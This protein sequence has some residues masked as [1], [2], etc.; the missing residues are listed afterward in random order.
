MSSCRI[1]KKPC[2]NCPFLKSSAA[3]PR[4]KGRLE[5]IVEGLLQDDLSTFICHKTLQREDEDEGPVYDGERMCAGAAIRLL[6]ERRPNV[7]MR[8]EGSIDRTLFPTW[9]AQFELIKE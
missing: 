8:V 3:I 1:L 2:S 7:I 6:K 4:R 9:E 5:S